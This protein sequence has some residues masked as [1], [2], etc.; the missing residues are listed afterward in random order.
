MR[1]KYTIIEY[2]NAT[3]NIAANFHVTLFKQDVSVIHPTITSK[4]KNVEKKDV[5]VDEI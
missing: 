3:K 1:I 2:K 5:G 4:V